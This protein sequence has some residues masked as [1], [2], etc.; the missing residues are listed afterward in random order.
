MG[1]LPCDDILSCIQLVFEHE[2]IHALINCFC[3]GSARRNDGP[4]NSP[5]PNDPKSG[6]SKIFMSIVNN[7]FGHETFTHTLTETSEETDNRRE[8][9]QEREKNAETNKR[10]LKRGG[11]VLIA[12]TILAKLGL[13]GEPRDYKGVIIKANPKFPI[14]SINGQK[15]KIAWRGFIPLPQ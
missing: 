11:V 2:L 10:L 3:S 6:H 8:L 1:G 5:L 9:N 7:L 14:I 15:Y 4:G 12:P 13:T